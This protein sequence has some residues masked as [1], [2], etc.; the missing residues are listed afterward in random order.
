MRH[1]RFFIP[2]HRRGGRAHLLVALRVFAVTLIAVA[3]ALDVAL[4]IVQDP[5]ALPGPLGQVA[6]DR[7]I[8]WAQDNILPLFPGLVTVAAEPLPAVSPAAVVAE[9]SP[10]AEAVAAVPTAVATATSTPVRNPADSAAALP[11]PLPPTPTP[12]PVPKPERIVIPS[13]ELDAPVIAVALTADGAMGTPRTAWEVGWYGPRPGERGN[14]LLTGHVDWVDAGRVVKGSFYGLSKLEP[15]SEVTIRAVDG[16]SRRFVVDWKKFYDAASAPLAE[17][18][19]PT[20]QPSVT[21]ITCGGK[22][23]RTLR[24]YLGRWVVRATL[25][26]QR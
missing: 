7:V 26:Q 25:V 11:T 14:A 16:S 23:D 21:L 3:V 4:L 17:I 20:E 6:E 24:S 8:P 15:G 5:A 1:G 22:F 13:L 10:T 9:P 18:T 12:V 19:G 2:T